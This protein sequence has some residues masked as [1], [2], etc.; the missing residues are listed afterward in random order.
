MDTKTL[1]GVEIKDESKGEVTAV[2]ATLGVRDHDGDF[3]RDGA[4][5][6]GAPVRISAYGHKSWDGLLPVGK[7]VIRVKGKRAILE[8][9]FFMNTT[10][11]RDTFETVKELSEAGLQEWSYGFDIN[12]YSFGEEKGEQVRYLDRVTVHEVSP[13]LLGAGIGTRTLSAKGREPGADSDGEAAP[14]RL[15]V[16]VPAVKRG[17]PCHE[18]EVASRAWDGGGTVAALPDDARPSQLRSVFAW[19]DPDGDP[20]AKSSYRFAHHHGVGGPANIRACLAGIAV[21]NG[22][23]GGAD[24]PDAD[25]KA[26]YNHLSAHLRD[27]DREPPELRDRSAG[28]VKGQTL[29]E[30]L[31]EA[32]AYMSGAIESA[33]RVAA[34]RA[35][36]GKTL[37]RGNTELLGWIGDDLKRLGALLTTPPA[38]TVSDEE[39]A[40]VFL[41]GLARLHEGAS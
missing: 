41:A 10:H 33:S 18:T 3:T 35:E 16:E 15:A 23:R 5:I 20:E 30:E 11:G 28:P 32:L 12:E 24:I 14:I 19:V 27:A 29:N 36:K 6:D 7:G 17:I 8:G 31:V 38:G 40:S 4:F 9:Q 25:R 26:V 13:V 34:L 22:A 37:S 2:F 39:L 21:L 1:R